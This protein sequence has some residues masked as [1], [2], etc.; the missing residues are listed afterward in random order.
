MVGKQ[1]IFQSASGSL[2]CLGNLGASQFPLLDYEIKVSPNLAFCSN[3]VWRGAQWVIL[4]LG[5]DLIPISLGWG[6]EYDNCSC[7][8][9]RFYGHFDTLLALWYHTMFK[10]DIFYVLCIPLQSLFQCII[11]FFSWQ[12]SPLSLGNSSLCFMSIM[13][14]MQSSFPFQSCTLYFF[15]SSRRDPL[16][17][18]SF[19][20]YVSHI[21]ITLSNWT[22][23]LTPIIGVSQLSLIG[24]LGFLRFPRSFVSLC[25]LYFDPQPLWH[26]AHFDHWLPSLGICTMVLWKDSSDIAGESSSGNKCP[27]QLKDLRIENLDL[28]WEF[29]GKHNHIPL[30]QTP[31]SQN[32]GQS[33]G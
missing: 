9:V 8:H 24:S 7:F 21:I 13:C 6:S 18:E 16:C 4:W 5:I 28:Q 20:L 31:I 12:H 11:Q 15:S 22:L 29:H 27:Q 23:L 32:Q 14:P 26:C 1:N 19:L 3:I 30:G 2:S 10:I 25:N 33:L 17:Y